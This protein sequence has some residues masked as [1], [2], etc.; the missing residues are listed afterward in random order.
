MT[1]TVTGVTSGESS[2]ASASHVVTL[3]SNNSGDLI[4]V[5]ISVDQEVTPSFPAGYSEIYGTVIDDSEGGYFDVQEA[6]ATGAASITVTLDGS[7]ELAYIAVVIENAAGSSSSANDL[8]YS[9]SPDTGAPS[10]AILSGDNLQLALFGSIGDTT[11]SSYPSDHASNNTEAGNAYC[12]VGLAVD[13]TTATHDPDT[14]T[15]NDDVSWAALV[16]VVET[17]AGTNHSLTPT[18]ITST[19]VDDPVDLTQVHKLTPTGITSTPVLDDVDLTYGN[20]LTPTGISATATVADSTVSQVHNVSASGLAVIPAVDTAMIVVEV[21]VD[22][23]GITTTPAVADSTVSQVHNVSP[24]GLASSPDV[25][26]P[27]LMIVGQLTPISI[28]SSADLGGGVISQVHSLSLGD[29]TT[30]GTTG[31]FALTQVHIVEPPDLDDDPPVID[32]P[33]AIVFSKR[34]LKWS[35]GCNCCDSTCWP[36][37]TPIGFNIPWAANMTAVPFSSVDDIRTQ[38]CDC[39]F[40]PTQLRDSNAASGSLAGCYATW[41]DSQVCCTG[42]HVDGFGNDYYILEVT[43]WWVEAILHPQLGAITNQGVELNYRHRRHWATIHEPG[44]NGTGIGDPCSKDWEIYPPDRTDQ[45]IDDWRMGNIVWNLYEAQS[46]WFDFTCPP[47]GETDPSI[48]TSSWQGPDGGLNTCVVTN[49]PFG[50]KLVM[51]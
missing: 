51:P 45:D 33:V 6:T 40:M 42:P 15:L 37:D 2:G 12:Q 25:G 16:Y 5:A 31:S 43:D 10:P 35:P 34:A 48:T 24:S 9:D 21:A 1:A 27:L 23:F 29:I 46:A 36:C 26:M 11:V 17:A 20:A 19:P 49:V 50:I 41:L 39:D 7:S 32:D 22:P 28:T 13:S 38:V 14:W 4:I 30:T 44:G 3:P 8:G 47:S 18:G